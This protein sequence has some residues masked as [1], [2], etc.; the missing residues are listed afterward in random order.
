M[1]CLPGKK[2]QPGHGRSGR[3]CRTA[4][5]L[6]TG[7]SPDDDVIPPTRRSG[8]DWAKFDDTTVVI[9]MPMSRTVP[10]GQ[11]GP[12]TLVCR[13]ESFAAPSPGISNS[14]IAGTRGSRA[15]VRR[16]VR[17]GYRVRVLVRP[18][19]AAASEWSVAISR[20]ASG[21]EQLPLS[22]FMARRAF[23]FRRSFASEDANAELVAD[24][25]QA[26][27]KARSGRARDRQLAGPSE[28]WRERRAVVFGLRARGSC[29]GRLRS[30][31]ARGCDSS[32]RRKR[33]APGPSWRRPVDA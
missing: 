13:F 27:K 29:C 26:R 24:Q 22:G 28:S 21:R 18:A 3:P 16:S 2:R 31:F 4:V 1:C 32:G 33:S 12:P 19:L 15:C 9:G 25:L 14:Q 10:R 20:S 5:R 17:T 11:A 23:C 30:S 8:P 7:S 6:S